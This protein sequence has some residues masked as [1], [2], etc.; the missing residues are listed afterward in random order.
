MTYLMGVTM[1]S[2]KSY[3]PNL[4]FGDWGDQR[5]DQS[6]AATKLWWE[7]AWFKHIYADRQVAFNIATAYEFLQI[8]Y[9]LTDKHT[10]NTN[11]HQ[12]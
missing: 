10:H 3:S 2:G 12:S 6:A 5:K 4:T 7:P 11:K 1:S 8:R 9:M